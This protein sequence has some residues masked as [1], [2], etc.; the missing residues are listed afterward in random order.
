MSYEF[1]V[2][3]PS[4]GCGECDLAKL[5]NSWR[6]SPPYI[7][8]TWTVRWWNYTSNIRPVLVATFSGWDPDGHTTNHRSWTVREFLAEGYQ[9]LGR[10]FTPLAN[11]PIPGDGKWGNL[12]HFRYEFARFLDD[13]SIDVDTEGAHVHVYC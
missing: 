13:V 10:M 9:A 5:A 2:T 3:A 6:P 7:C 1:E 12:D 4:C 8:G 11:V